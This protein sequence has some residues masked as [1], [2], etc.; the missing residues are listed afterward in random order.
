MGR[1]MDVA[2]EVAYLRE[3]AGHFRKLAEKA[4]LDQYMVAERL[5]KLAA[6]LDAKADELERRDKPG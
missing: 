3:K 2:A 5:Q 6:D 4:R 1:A